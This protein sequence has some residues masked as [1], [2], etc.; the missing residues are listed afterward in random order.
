LD[1]K[2]VGW[3]AQHSGM[4]EKRNVKF[5]CKGTAEKKIDRNLQFGKRV[6]CTRKVGGR[7]TGSQVQKNREARCL[8]SVG[9]EFGLDAMKKREDG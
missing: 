8:A 6:Q 5:P 9:I 2:K 7:K 4:N 3:K 1:L